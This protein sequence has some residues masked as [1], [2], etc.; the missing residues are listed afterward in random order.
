M[1][2]AMAPQTL[3]PMQQSTITLP[4]T[5]KLAAGRAMTLE[6]REAGVLQVAHGRLWAT[7]DGPH[8]GPL[9]D[10]GDRILGTGDRWRLGP[11]QRLVIEGWNGDSPAYFSWDPLPALVPNAAPGLVQVNQSW[12]DL[13]L[14]VLLGGGAIVRLFAGL[15]GLVLETLSMTSI[16][17]GWRGRSHHSTNSNA[18]KSW[19]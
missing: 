16:I 17:P 1:E 5:W 9:N 15:A 4:G 12:S 3:T 10:L 13:R 6:P 19:T 11:G 8:S 14:A 18:M 7:S 2:N